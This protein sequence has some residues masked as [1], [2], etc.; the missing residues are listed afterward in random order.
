MGGRTLILVLLSLLSICNCI[1]VTYDSRSFII[2]GER[3]LLISGSIHYPR[4]TPEM[5]PDLIKKAKAGGLNTIETYVFWNAHEPQQREYDFTGNLDLMRFLK[6]IRDEGMY[7]ILRIGPYVCAEWNFGGFPVW[8]HNLEGVKFRT[9]NAVFMNEMQNFTTLIV[10][11]AKTE[12][13]FARQGG[14]IIITQIENEFGNVEE[15]YGDAGKVY[16]NWAANMAVS[17]DTGSPWIMCQQKDAPSI[18]INTCN[19]WYCDDFTPNNASSPKIWTENWA[20][21]FM[22]WGSV[23]PKRAAEDV[24]FAVARFYQRGGSLQNYYM[25]HGGTNFGRTAGGPYITTS[26]D[27][28]APLDEYGNLNQPKY[29]HSTQLHNLLMSMEKTLTEGNVTEIDFGNGAEGTVF[30]NGQTTSCFFSNKNTSSDATIKYE[31]MEITVPAWSVS[32]F[33]DCQTE[34]YNTAKINTQTSMMVQRENGA[35]DEPSALKWAWRPE[36]LDVAVVQ[37]KGSMHASEILDQKV[38]NDASDYLWY[39]TS[40]NIDEKDPVWSNNMSIKINGTGHVLHAYVNGEYVGSKWGKYDIHNYAFE[41]PI[42]L[43]LGK[44]QISLLSALVGLK[45][46]GAFFDDYRAGVCGYVYIV[47]RNGDETITKDL[48]NNQ[49]I[50]KDNL[51]GLDNQLYSQQSKFASQWQSGFLPI[52]RSMTWYKT[53]FKAPLGKDPVVLDLLGLGKGYAWVNGNNL[54]RYWPSF[55][56]PEDGCDDVCDYRATYDASQCNYGCGEPTQRWYHVPRDFLS[57]T[58]VNELVLFEEFGGNPSQVNLKTV[59]VGSACGSAYEHKTME[60]SCQGRSISQIKFASFGNPTGTCGS[61]TK[62]T[63]EGSKDAISILQKACVG[64][65]TCSLVANENIFGPTSCDNASK[66][67][68]VE[69][70]CAI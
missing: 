2:D 16:I 49:W 35:E 62:G 20:G 31:D 22:S 12:K 42:K 4:S 34:A 55:I 36:N 29:G 24:A 10:D 47:G 19:G 18:V 38:L 37:G 23:R 46:Y 6:T 65:E 40:V 70:T 8:L 59:V 69:A 68:L 30:V 57:A 13:L 17:L 15:P 26:Y 61:F 25:Y 28:D 44:N 52:N 9:A 1:E 63:C 32:I 14:P 7:I 33:P 58:G 45:N 66:K 54:G 56:A 48:S 43:K 53:T 50:Y 41:T 51:H 21:W 5:W 3:K 27:Y 60:L 67:L 39:M 11:M 64:K